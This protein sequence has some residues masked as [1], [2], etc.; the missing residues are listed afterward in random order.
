MSHP[1]VVV[2]GSS[3]T[4]GNEL[5]GR[6][7]DRGY[8]VTGVD[9][10]ENRWSDR[11][12]R[13][14]IQADLRDEDALAELPADVDLVVHLAANA[15]VH[16]LVENPDLAR[17]NIETTYN[18]LEYARRNQADV[19]FGSSREVYGNKGKV[20]Y[21]ESD[22]HI[23]ECESPY[24]ASKVAG[25]A[26]VKSYQQC[27]DLESCILRFSNVYGRF[28]AS[29]RVVPLFIAQ[30][31]RGRDMTVYGSDKVLDF[32]YL[33]DCVEGILH[34]IED[35]EKAKRTT[36]NVASGRGASLVDLAESVIELTDSGSTLHVEPNRT[37]EISRYVADISKA[38]KIL[39]FEPSHS[40]E[41]GLERTVEWYQQNDHLFDEILGE[42]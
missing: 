2:T 14:T 20:V 10:T 23:D 8:D 16:K 36:F 24:T 29:D 33:D 25:E 32:T 42:R 3:G 27:Y 15:R 28:D 4:I 7:L 38:R 1:S 35:F 6:L 26:L 41:S 30:A 5:V 17:D 37:G 18:V 34:A 22:T 11:V 21:G 19:V 13:A 39:G 40:L 9:Y 12:A 31:T